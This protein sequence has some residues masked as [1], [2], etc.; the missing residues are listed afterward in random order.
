MLTKR[1]SGPSG[2]FLPSK[3]RRRFL[4]VFSRTDRWWDKYL[5]GYTHVSLCEV[6]EGFLIVHDPCLNG[7]RTTF[8]VMPLPGE[9]DAYKVIEVVT[10]PTKANRLIKPIFQTCTTLVQ[11]LAGIDLGAI[12]VQTLYDRLLNPSTATKDGIREITIWPHWG[13]RC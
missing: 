12:L 8:R 3:R 7:C 10:C 13:A 5:P 9:W 4:F 11:Y 1:K 6:V 2:C